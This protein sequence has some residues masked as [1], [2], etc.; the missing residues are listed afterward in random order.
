MCNNQGG[1][2]IGE[3][4]VESGAEGGVDNI[5]KKYRMKRRKGGRVI[6]I[7]RAPEEGRPRI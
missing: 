3:V 5:G 1:K 2:G 7:R 6:W 4:R